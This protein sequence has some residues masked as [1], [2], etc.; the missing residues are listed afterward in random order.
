MSYFVNPEN[1]RALLLL[2]DFS[3][4]DSALTAEDL[5]V[6][7]DEVDRLGPF[8]GIKIDPKQPH[9]FP[10]TF[11]NPMQYPPGVLIDE[12]GEVPFGV[13]AWVALRAHQLSEERAGVA[14]ADQYWLAHNDGTRNNL[15]YGLKA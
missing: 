9:E 6:A 7:S 15:L 1:A 8:K 14:R 3:I 2:Q 4:R 12:P 11:V 10:R 5:R 13:L